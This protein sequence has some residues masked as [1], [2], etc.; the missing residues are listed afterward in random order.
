[1]HLERDGEDYPDKLFADE[2]RTV[3]EL[4]MVVDEVNVSVAWS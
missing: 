4:V 1:M 2:V 3:I